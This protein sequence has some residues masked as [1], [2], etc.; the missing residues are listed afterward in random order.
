MKPSLTTQTLIESAQTFCERESNIS[1]TELYG[2][3]DGKA[4]GT[5]VEQAF[6]T[7]LAE[8]YTVA[9]GNAAMGID[10]PAAD[11]LTDIKVTSVRQ[12][13]SSCPFRDA[14]QKIYGLGY[15]LLIFVYDKI[16]DAKHKTARL[17]FVNCVYTDKART[18]DYQTTLAL[19]QMLQ[20]NANEEEIV[21]Y[22]M[23]RNIPADEIALTQLAQEILQNPPQQGYLTI[24]N[25]LQWRLQY[26]RVVSL[27]EEVA[28][29][30]PIIR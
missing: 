5:F 24:S 10:L 21:A 2:V 4:V 3:T 29:I 12:P 1:H 19:R 11:I 22:L 9:L 25:A 28:G 27:A 16:D 13:Q 8:N 15:N 30:T 17:Q 14:K 18:A 6:K 26:G 7:F 20:N 23:D